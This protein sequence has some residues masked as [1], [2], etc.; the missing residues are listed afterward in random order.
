VI[1]FRLLKNHGT[2]IV[3]GR[4]FHVEG[5]PV[6]ETVL[7]AYGNHRYDFRNEVRLP[8]GPFEVADSA[9]T[10]IELDRLA[11]DGVVEVLTEDAA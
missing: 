10:R 7:D 4:L 9:E 2:L 5:T 3:G 8:Q 11:D 1:R 6:R